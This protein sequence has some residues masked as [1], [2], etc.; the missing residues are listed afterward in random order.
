MFVDSSV[1]S[2]N[3]NSEVRFYIISWPILKMMPW[4]RNLMQI[5]WWWKK[6]WG[7]VSNFT[8]QSVST[9]GIAAI[10]AG[11]FK[12]TFASPISTKPVLELNSYFGL[13]WDSTT[14]MHH[15]HVELWQ[16]S[17]SFW[18]EIKNKKRP[19]LLT[20]GVVHYKAWSL[21]ARMII[22]LLNCL[23]EW[24]VQQRR[25]NSSQKNTLLNTVIHWRI[26]IM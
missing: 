26:Q 1:W 22:K 20:M 3:P 11:A 5:R 6:L 10:C 4:L 2:T 18:N 16:E 9:N 14:N 15:E 8:I 17:E 24:S 7:N 25:Y 12:D 19:I 23:T 13:F 21:C